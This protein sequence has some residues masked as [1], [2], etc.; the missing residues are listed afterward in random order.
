MGLEYREA[1]IRQIRDHAKEIDAR[2]IIDE[3]LRKAGWNPAD[4]SQVLTESQFKVL[5]IVLRKTDLDH[6]WQG[7]IVC[8]AI[9]QGRLYSTGEQR[10]AVGGD[11]GEKICYRALYRKT[12]GPAPRKTDQCSFCL[13]Y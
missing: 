1:W 7:Y 8:D 10:Q 2:I 11:R 9:R 12:T 3:S 13:S 4:K 5:Q 6:L